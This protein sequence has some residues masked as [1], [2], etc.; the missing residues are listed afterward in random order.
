[1]SATTI[2]DTATLVALIRYTDN[3][4]KPPARFTKKLAAWERSNGVGRL[5]RKEPPRPNPKWTAPASFT[6]HEGNFSSDGVILV[7]IM[8]THSADSA[9][10]FEAA[11]EP[12]T[13][14]VRVLLDFG[15]CTELL[16]LAESVT[17]A[18]LW[19]AREGYRN[20]QLEI[21]GSD[22]GERA[23]RPELAA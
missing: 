7:T 5:V 23:R 6:L 3:S 14:Q 20:A 4:P 10:T 13:G 18:K 21:V 1:M 16:H 15:G 22:D 2:L 11:E 19:I 12:Q 8:R 9:L 17:A